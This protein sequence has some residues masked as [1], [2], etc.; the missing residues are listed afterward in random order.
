MTN[1]NAP[2]LCGYWKYWHMNKSS[3]NLHKLRLEIHTHT[4]FCLLT[5]TQFQF[6]LCKYWKDKTIMTTPF[7]LLTLI[8]KTIFISLS[9]AKKSESP[10]SSV[11]FFIRLCYDAAVCSDLVLH[12]KQHEVGRVGG[13]RK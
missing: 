11:H 13:R 10:F 1:R 6:R 9:W 7:S 2:I 3:L 12:L 8:M 5:H 4:N